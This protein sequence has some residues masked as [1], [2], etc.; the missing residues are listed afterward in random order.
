MS[1]AFDDFCGGYTPPQQSVTVTRDGNAIGR[2][3][4]LY[5]KLANTPV[6]EGL[7]DERAMLQEQLE[8]AVE[9][10]EKSLMT[11]TFEALGDSAYEQLQLQCPPRPSQL[12]A[13]PDTTFDDERFKFE[14][15]VKC[16]VEPKLDRERV[17]W[18]KDNLSAGQYNKLCEAAVIVNVGGDD[19]PKVGTLS[20]RTGLSG[21]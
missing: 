13:N 6:G 19:V 9:A 12:K 21:Q 1:D 14:L 4:E 17:Q 2:I 8:G 16:A 5:E 3:A 7:N 20:Q 15:I 18:L 11:V 10:A